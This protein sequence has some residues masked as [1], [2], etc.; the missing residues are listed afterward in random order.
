MKEKQEKDFKK[1]EKELGVNFHNKNLLIQAFIHR[2]Y[3][4]EHNRTGFSNNERLEFLGDAVLELIVT[5]FLFEK[6]LDL[7]EGE[8][9]SYR[10]ALVNTHSL[11]E[12]ARNLNFNDYLFLSK[13]ES[14]DSGKARLAI[15]ADA[16]EAVIGAI[17]LD[18]GY[19][20]ARD[21]VEKSLL[22]QLGEIIRTGTYKD[23]KSKIQEI[24]Q[25]RFSLT[26]SYKVLEETGP[27]HK[28]QFTVGIYLGKE[29]IARGQGRS[30]QEAETEAAKNALLQISWE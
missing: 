24:S 17:F 10:A 19:E 30:K 16:Y 20:A 18:R 11:G 27:D 23:A 5:N 13:G 14:K 29:E 9:T 8:L 3:I 6:Y 1:L 7:A 4:N 26:P 21:F 2:S 12:V 22:T 15:L 25:E 28:K